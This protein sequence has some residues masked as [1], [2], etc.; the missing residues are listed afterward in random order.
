MY[1]HL[2]QI[3][4]QVVLILISLLDTRVT[5]SSVHYISN[6]LFDVHRQLYKYYKTHEVMYTQR[7]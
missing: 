4:L 3:F 1:F 5:Y 6:P 7:K 2:T